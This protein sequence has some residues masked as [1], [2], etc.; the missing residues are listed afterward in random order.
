MARGFTRREMLIGGIGVAGLGAAG[1]VAANRIL[2][3]EAPASPVGL[4][5]TAPAA[6]VAIQRCE[7][8]EPAV[9]AARM[10]AALDGIGGLGDLVRGKSVAI[11]INLTGT[12]QDVFGRSASRTYQVHPAVVAA[13][14]AALDAAGAKRITILEC[15]AYKQPMEAVLTKACGWDLAAVKSAGGQKVFF[16]NTRNRGSW[17]SYSRLK[18]PGGGYLWPAFDFNSHYEKTDCFISVAKLKDHAAAGITAACK[19]V[20]GCIPMADRKSVV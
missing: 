4:S 17:P 3:K 9:V 10:K 7:S 2:R 11:K 1:L 18:V 5:A 13:L 16:E 19:N 6:A 15:C 20:F 8:Y 14:A 12:A